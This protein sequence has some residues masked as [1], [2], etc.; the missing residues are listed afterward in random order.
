MEKIKST[1]PDKVSKGDIPV[2][3]RLRLLDMKQLHAVL[4]TDM[5]GQP[6]T[7]LVAYALI[8]EM[9]GIIFTTPKSTRKYKN[10][11]KNR[12]VSLL[13]NTRS[14]TRKDYMNAE[15]LTILGNA[16]PLRKSKHW[17]KYA[18]IFLKKHPKLKE[19]LHSSETALIL[20]EIVRCIHVTRF[21]SVS[22]WNK[23]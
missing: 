19:I 20:V 16:I 10:I 4:A 11:L 3:G 12:R 17:L 21:Q 22:V 15:S 18:D 6:Y 13:I 23:D 8:P 1:I 14:N 2:P 5:D 9:K 7:S